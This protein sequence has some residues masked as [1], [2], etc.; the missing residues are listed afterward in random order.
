MRGILSWEKVTTVAACE[1]KL[2]AEQRLDYQCCWISRYK[3]DNWS[4]ER[5]WKCEG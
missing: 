4:H 2:T 1:W 5:E 3:E